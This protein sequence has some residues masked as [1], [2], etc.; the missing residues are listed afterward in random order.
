MRGLSSWRSTSRRALSPAARGRTFGPYRANRAATS[1]EVNP[2]GLPSS[3]R[4]TSSGGR[5]CQASSRV[6]IS[7]ARS[8]MRSLLGR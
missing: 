2:S 5:A 8:G 6:S 7:S 4:S 3:R 1:L